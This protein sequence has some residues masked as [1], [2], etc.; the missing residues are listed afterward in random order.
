M[1]LLRPALVAAMLALAAPAGVSGATDP[2]PPAAREAFERGL[3]A[4]ETQQWLSAIRYFSEAQKTAPASPAVMFNLGLAHGKAGQ[5][6]PAIAWLRAYLAAAPQAPNAAA[7]TREILRLEIATEEKIARV[8]REALAAAAASQYAQHVTPKVVLIQAATGDV[9]SAIKSGAQASDAWHAYALTLA[10]ARLVEKTE[11]AARRITA[12]DKRRE[13]YETLTY[14]LVGGLSMW[15]TES[16]VTQTSVAIVGTL[17]PPPPRKAAGAARAAAARIDDPKARARAMA[18]VLTLDF[19]PGDLPTAEAVLS[20][21]GPLRYPEVPVLAASALVEAV[22]KQSIANGDLAGAIRF[23][24]HALSIDPWLGDHALSIVVPVLL[25]R[26]DVNSARAI[27]RTVA[28]VATGDLRA[29]AEV[30]L[31][32]TA[33]ALAVAQRVQCESFKSVFTNGAG[34]VVAWIATIQALAGDAVAAKATINAQLPSCARKNTVNAD[35]VRYYTR[36]VAHAQIARRDFRGA[37][38]TFRDNSPY[39]QLSEEEPIIALLRTAPSDA[40]LRTLS[41][42]IPFAPN[43]PPALLRVAAALAQR[44][45]DSEA[46]SALAEAGRN[47]LSKTPTWKL[48]ADTMTKMARALEIRG[49]PTGAAAIRA[50]MPAQPNLEVAAWSKLALELSSQDAAVDLPKAVK[51]TVSQ[52]SPHL[53]LGEV[54]LN[55]ADWLFGLRGAAVWAVAS[56]PAPAR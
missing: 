1:T 36:V 52:P 40:E 42:T 7:V 44:N 37:A 35:M 8:M 34:D 15:R 30:V 12:P 25:A 21:L 10:R 54:A 6:L 19:R 3:V 20:V 4:A 47:W 39:T 23:V 56:T 5:E 43:Y 32:D 16:Q 51:A 48:D 49:D 27:A 17:F 14:A 38:E 41:Q 22:L 24:D 28:S 45:L 29:K 2:V 33:P 11:E 31:G 46:A 50:A 13:V 53:R 9:E 18:N 26:G 55:L